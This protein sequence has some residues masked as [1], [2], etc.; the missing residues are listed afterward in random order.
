LETKYQWNSNWSLSGGY[1]FIL[2]GDKDEIAQIKAGTV[3]T[4]DANGVS[5]RLSLSDYV[6]LPNISKHKA[7][8]KINYVTE[9]GYFANC[10]LV[11][12]SKWAVNN[13]DGNQV[14]DTGDSFAAGY[15]SLY[16]S[17]GKNYSNGLSLQVG[18]D[19]M[20]NY[21]DANNLSNLPGR[22]F[23]FS[24]KYQIINKK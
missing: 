7:Q 12:R 4:R 1:Q 10:R 18:C 8:F 5:S 6:G 24:I 23:Y 15:L 11:Y 2:T 3:Y 16:S 21:V 19:N 22:T 13:T 20:T 14:Y 9:D 17:V